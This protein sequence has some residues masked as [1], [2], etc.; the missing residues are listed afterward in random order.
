MNA[1]KGSG[2]EVELVSKRKHG[3]QRYDR[4]NK[5]KRGAVLLRLD[6]SALVHQPPPLCFTI[7]LYAALSADPSVT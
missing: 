3:G 7:S 2:M 4:V 5:R 1:D 6:M